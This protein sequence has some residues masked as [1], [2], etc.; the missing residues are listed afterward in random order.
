MFSNQDLNSGKIK[1]CPYNYDFI[2][3]MSVYMI[4][5]GL[6]GEVHGLKPSVMKGCVAKVSRVSGV[7]VMI[8]VGFI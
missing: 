6:F 3:G 7:P 2:L 5:H 8:Q 1:A 4:G